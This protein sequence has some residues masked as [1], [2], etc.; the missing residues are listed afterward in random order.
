M[1]TPP[2][3]T[4]GGHQKIPLPRRYAQ[5]LKL[6]N[7]STKETISRIDFL[8]KNGDA[9]KLR[10]HF[11]YRALPGYEDRLEALRNG[12]IE[13]DAEAEG[14]NM[15]LAVARGPR[16]ITSVLAALAKAHKAHTAQRVWYYAKAV[17]AFSWTTP[18]DPE[19]GV[20]PWTLP[21]EAYTV[22]L[23][24]YARV[25]SQGAHYRF[26]LQKDHRG[27]KKQYVAVP[28]I[29]RERRITNRGKRT[30]I[31]IWR[32]GEYVRV[33]R[34]RAGRARRWAL[35][36]YRSARTAY[37]R[38]APMAD[39]IL[40]SSA[41]YSTASSSSSQNNPHHGLLHPD[42][43]LPSPDAIFYNA[44]LKIVEP[45]TGRVP[46]FQD[47]EEVTSQ[48]RDAE[49]LYEMFGVAP[50][51]ASEGLVMVGRDMLDGGFPIPPGLRPYF[52]G[53]GLKYEANDAK[54]DPKLWKSLYRLWVER[55]IK[56]RRKRDRARG[57]RP[58][59]LGGRPWSKKSLRSMRSET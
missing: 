13:V 15:R 46:K 10:R 27:G 30:K 36:I 41:S 8:T 16:V 51:E 29:P 22:M 20:L 33:T 2:V 34:Q 42:H 19:R 52:V 31:K 23:G 49:H 44:I 28:V 50:P 48:L 14:E 58:H 59:K 9:G 54:D 57:L 21:I 17:E 47:L 25:L 7:I 32:Q 11:E 53:S 6:P 38:Y 26:E 24:I 5:L 1:V 37:D 12:F 4:R 39:E 3:Q 40:S 35:E 43:E 56:P 18:P 55:K 45:D